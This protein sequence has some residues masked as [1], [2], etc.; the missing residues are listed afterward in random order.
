MHTLSCLSVLLFNVLFV[1]TAMLHQEWPTL[2]YS[3][4][5]MHLLQHV[6]FAWSERMNA[7]SGFHQLQTRVGW[8]DRLLFA[9]LRRISCSCSD[10]PG[11]V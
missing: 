3:F 9:R 6:E 7:E 11:Y 2:F 10:R 8:T 4:M 1:T 5:P